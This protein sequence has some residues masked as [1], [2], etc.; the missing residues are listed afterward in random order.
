MNRP[1]TARHFWVA[2]CIGAFVAC[3]LHF[4]WGVD[5]A[6]AAQKLPP[7]LRYDTHG[8]VEYGVA[9]TAD[10]IGNPTGLAKYWRQQLD[11]YD[12]ADATAQD[13]LRQE[14]D[15]FPGGLPA[16]ERFAIRQ[17]DTVR[18]VGTTPQGLIDLLAAADPDGPKVGG[19]ETSD[20]QNF[21]SVMEEVLAAHDPLA[22]AVDA[23]RIWFDR[24]DR[25]QIDHMVTVTGIDPATQTVFLN[26][27]GT[28][29]GRQESVPLAE[30]MNAAGAGGTYYEVTM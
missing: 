29:I 28:P 17:G 5:V 25:G 13:M 15:P 24:R 21:L 10:V 2:I 16:L 6:A 18:K 3:A 19:M 22:V 12:C 1:L 7:N 27:S 23:E 20:E 14:H 9:P 30:F 11:S 4:V 26:D 8:A